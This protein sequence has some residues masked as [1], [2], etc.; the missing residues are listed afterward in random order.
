M[1]D[2]TDAEIEIARAIQHLRDLVAKHRGVEADMIAWAGTASP[3]GDKRRC[4]G[5]MAA[6]PDTVTTTPILRE[7]EPNGPFGIGDA[8][9]TTRRAAVGLAVSARGAG[10]DIQGGWGREIDTAHI[11]AVEAEPEPDWWD[12][13]DTDG[14]E[15]CP[16][17]QVIV[18]CSVLSTMP[19]VRLPM[20]ADYRHLKDIYA[21]LE[22][23]YNHEV[24]LVRPQG[25][26]T[27]TVT[28]RLVDPK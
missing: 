19:D 22:G 12:D 25:D 8:Y 6:Q 3:S 15:P 11:P 14:I 23:G 20:A 2:I 18:F 1:S 24:T 10:H 7:P 13:V 16:N 26:A 4:V 21:L 27:A 28:Y 9:V 5:W 17:G